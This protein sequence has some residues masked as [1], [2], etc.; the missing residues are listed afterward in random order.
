MGK[1]F[2]FF[3]G[4]RDEERLK[5]YLLKSNV[6][7]LFEGKNP[8]PIEITEFPPTFS[9]KGWFIMYLYKEEW[10]ELVIRNVSTDM[11]RIDLLSSP[12]IELSRTV[13]RSTAKEI[14]PGR[15]WFQNSYFK[16]DTILNKCSDINNFYLELMRQIKIILPKQKKPFAEGN[17]T[18]YCSDSIKKM[19]DNGYRIM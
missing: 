2:N 17:T 18:I 5:K 6:K 8:M 13:I 19:L 12:V 11:K 16:E 7:I 4:E 9:G 15:I 10:G 3:M 1:Q 14:T